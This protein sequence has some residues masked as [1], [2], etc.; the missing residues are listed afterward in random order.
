MDFT[1]Q[2]NITSKIIELEYKQTCFNNLSSKL[3]QRKLCRT[4][5]MDGSN[6]DFK[7]HGKIFEQI[8][9]RW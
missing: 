4:E 5:L 9:K 8:D 1:I 6:V 7:Y 3:Q 2:Y